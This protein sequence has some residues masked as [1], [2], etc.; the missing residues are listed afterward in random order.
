[1]YHRPDDGAH[2]S[3]ITILGGRTA[4]FSQMPTKLGAVCSGTN[5]HEL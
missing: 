4:R 5:T 1:M 3:D 2:V